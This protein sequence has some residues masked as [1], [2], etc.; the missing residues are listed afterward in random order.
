MKVA[1]TG[2]AGHV[3]ANLVRALLARGD[4]VRVLVHTDTR[5]IAGLPVEHCHGSVTDSAAVLRLVDG[6]QRVYHLAAKVSIE[7]RERA[8]L[9][10]VNV[11]GMQCVVEACRAAGVARLVH[12]SS[13]HAFAS[14]P[15]HEPITEDRALAT[16]R[17]L[18]GYDASKVAAER[19][20]QAAVASGLD[21]VVLNP[22]A[23]LGPHDCR[24]SHL[25]EVLLDLYHQRLPGLVAGGFDWV[26]VRDVAAGIL[27]AADQA[28]AGSRYLLGGQRATVAELAQLVAQVTGRRAPWLVAPMW[29]A[30]AMAPGAEWAARLAGRRPLFTPESL[31]ALRNHLEISSS[32]ARQELGY[33]PRSLETTVRD[34]FE[35]FREAGMLEP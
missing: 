23:I 13:I 25:G 2:A 20:V 29:L 30:R 5:G 4:Q 16:G 7:P 34:T 1:V 17:D 9:H 18:P 8:E 35:W 6:V 28:P 26:D 21:A 12:V 10:R 33:A 24:P 22:T 19:V 15:R 32:R 14:Y 3:G 27:A 11:G 31:Y